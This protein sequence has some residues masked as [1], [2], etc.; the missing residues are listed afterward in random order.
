MQE[1]CKYNW[2]KFRSYAWEWQ[3][4]GVIFTRVILPCGHEWKVYLRILKHR[5]YW[6][7]VGQ[8]RLPLKIA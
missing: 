4:K 2:D 3:K 5:D 6:I 7:E 1:C 8:M